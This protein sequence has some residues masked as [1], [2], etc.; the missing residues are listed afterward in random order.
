VCKR[1]SIKRN[2]PLNPLLIEGK[3]QASLNL[4]LIILTQIM[5]TLFNLIKI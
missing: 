3:Q 5:Q 2:T 4:G 1:K